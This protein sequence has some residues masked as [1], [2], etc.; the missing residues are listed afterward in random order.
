MALYVEDL[1][2]QDLLWRMRLR[3]I[4]TLEH[5]LQEVAAAV[6]L[7]HFSAAAKAAIQEAAN[8]YPRLLAI[9]L[10]ASC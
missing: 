5:Y 7:R 10:P 9:R 3:H 8:L 1:H 6:S 2:L 4:H